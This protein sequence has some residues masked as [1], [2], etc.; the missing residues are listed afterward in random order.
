MENELYWTFLPFSVLRLNLFDL[1][2]WSKDKAVADNEFESI[3]ICE[4]IV[5]TNCITV[6]ELY[7]NIAFRFIL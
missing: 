1:F 2:I 7:C 5:C 3:V 4:I 6:N